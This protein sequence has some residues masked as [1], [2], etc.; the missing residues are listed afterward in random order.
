MEGNSLTGIKLGFSESKRLQSAL[1]DVQRSGTGKR[2]LRRRQV[3]HPRKTLQGAGAR[4]VNAT[5][6]TA[7]SQP[8]ELAASLRKRSC[9]KWV[10]K[11]EQ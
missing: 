4:Y 1:S 3:G 10:D 7:R 11:R 9:G 5:F 6:A 2:A 8:G